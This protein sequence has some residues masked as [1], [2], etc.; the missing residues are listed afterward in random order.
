MSLGEVQDQGGWGLVILDPA[1]ARYYLPLNP[2]LQ[3]QLPVP[4]QGNQGAYY[5]E[6]V[7][8][9]SGRLLVNR[10]CCGGVPVRTTSSLIEEVSTSGAPRHL[11]AIGFADRTH[12]SFDATGRWVLYLSGTDLFISRNGQR[13]TLLTSGLIA[14]AWIPPGRS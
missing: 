6:G 13:P 5:R 9:P 7:F 12:S 14:A 11:I 1:T 4:V 3:G 8:L 10:V 2:P